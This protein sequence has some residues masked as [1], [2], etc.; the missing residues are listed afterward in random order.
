V[1]AT[2]TE[3]ANAVLVGVRIVE[4]FLG[5]PLDS[6]PYPYP[7]PTRSRRKWQ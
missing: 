2:T 1:V 4:S 5:R 3:I 6:E 7:W